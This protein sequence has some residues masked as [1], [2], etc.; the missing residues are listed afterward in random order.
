MNTSSSGGYLTPIAS[1]PA[2]LV[3]DDQALW[4]FLQN[5]F[6]GITGTIA[7]NQFFYNWQTEPANL[8]STPKTSWASFG[9]ES[10]FITQYEFVGHVPAAPPMFAYDEYQAHEDLK[11]L[12]SFYGPQAHTNAKILRD[13][14]QIPQNREPLLNAGMGLVNVGDIVTVPELIKQDWLMRVDFPVTIRRAVVRWYG[15]NDIAE[16][17]VTIYTDVP[18][19]STGAP[20]TETVTVT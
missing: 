5:L 19:G 6:V 17:D 3:L 14:L 13:G 8:P 4:V 20:F 7:G 15:V 1:P 9:V 12:L 10:T 2:P 16:A 11:I 18:S